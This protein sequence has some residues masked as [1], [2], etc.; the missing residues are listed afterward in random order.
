MKKDKCVVVT[1]CMVEDRELD[2]SKLSGARF[3]I[4][5]KDKYKIPEIIDKGEKK[6]SRES[7]KISAFKGHTRV[8]VKIQ[9]G[10]NNV[11]S[12]CKV[13][14]VRGRAKSRPFKDILGECLTLIKNGTKEIVLTGICLG[15]YGK[16]LLERMNLSG[17]IQ[18]ICKIEGDWRLRLSSIEPKDID[19]TLIQQLL[20]EPRLCKHLHIPFQ[21]G[22]TYILKKMDRPYRQEDYL[23]IVSKLRDYGRFSR[24]ERGEFSQHS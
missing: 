12:F 14:I 9:D 4:K 20:T 3:I 5:N 7:F 10:C 19:K 8:F 6:A 21:A 2:L 22:D 17:L 16:D 13:R 11:C 1:G 23:N 18:E 15:S 24:G